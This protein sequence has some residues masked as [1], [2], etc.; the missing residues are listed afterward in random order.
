MFDPCGAQL[1]RPCSNIGVSQCCRR[2]DMIQVSVF[3]NSANAV[4]KK[5][6]VTPGH[7]PG[8]ACFQALGAVKMLDSRGAQLC[9]PCLFSAHRVRGRIPHTP[10]TQITQSCISPLSFLR[11]DFC[12]VSTYTA[13]Q[14]DEIHATFVQGSA[15]CAGADWQSLRYEAGLP[16]FCA[17][18][19]Q[20]SFMA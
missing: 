6:K 7:L 11:D 20:G 10:Y 12:Q 18:K 4:E 9:R 15:G 8:F 2:C 5:G 13:L 3:R 16:T 1:C 17:S 14:C 19:D